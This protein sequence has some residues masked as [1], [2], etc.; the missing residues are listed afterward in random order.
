ME[1]ANS[2][3]SSLCNWFLVLVLSAGFCLGFTV[4][5][6]AQIP[7]IV[8]LDETFN[9]DKWRRQ[10]PTSVTYYYGSDPLLSVSFEYKGTRYKVYSISSG[11]P[12]NKVKIGITP[13]FPPEGS[14][15]SYFN[16]YSG[17]AGGDGKLKKFNF[18]DT[19][20]NEWPGSAGFR[21]VFIENDDRTQNG[22]LRI[23]AID[24][25]IGE[26]LR[27]AKWYPEPTEDSSGTS[28]GG[29]IEVL[30]D[31]ND[32]DQGRWRICDR[33][34]DF[35]FGE[36]EAKVACRQMGFEPDGAEAIDI[37]DAVRAEFS[38]LN[39][40]EVWAFWAYA[41]QALG[42]FH[43]PV[44]LDKVQCDGDEE[45]LVDCNHLGL[46]V[47]SENCQASNTAGVLCGDT[48]SSTTTSST[49]N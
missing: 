45:K 36:E 8:L 12:T 18:G 10:T 35:D 43:T 28:I 22:R 30:K 47:V 5:A 15:R 42:V 44:L 9:L 40:I 23:T 49:D 7:E 16:L 1:F 24:E 37:G 13:S 4:N 17:S 29:R 33:G 38:S 32:V 39:G 46:G 11:H 25:S 31:P 21:A 20:N 3:L 26:H 6:D 34:G 41:F 27:F 48:S 19:N 14:Q 2:R